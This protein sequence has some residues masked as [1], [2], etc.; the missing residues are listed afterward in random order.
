VDLE[1]RLHPHQAKQIFASD[2]NFSFLSPCEMQAATTVEQPNGRLEI[3]LTRLY[4]FHLAK[5][6]QKPNG[7][8][9]ENLKPIKI[10]K[11]ELI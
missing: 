8:K 5:Q 10:K 6:S 2:S 7:K 9:S 1:R 3:L 4:R 11:F